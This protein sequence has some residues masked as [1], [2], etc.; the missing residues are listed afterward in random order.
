MIALVAEAC[1]LDPRHKHQAPEERLPATQKILA[2]VTTYRMDP[3]MRFLGQDT[4]YSM[5]FINALLKTTP[6]S[7]ATD[8][9]THVTE[10]CRSAWAK[11]PQE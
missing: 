1:W 9:A 5:L 11:N 2:I 3:S 8:T 4:C 6:E 10:R 7:Q